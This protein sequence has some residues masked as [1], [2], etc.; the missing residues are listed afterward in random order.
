MSFLRDLSPSGWDSL[1]RKC[2]LCCYEKQLSPG[3]AVYDLSEPCP[4]LDR[5]SQLCTVY[6]NRYRKNPRCRPVNLFTAM[7]ASY[8]PLCCGYTAWAKKYHLR[9]VR[10]REIS[11]IHSIHPACK[12]DDE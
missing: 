5:E 2:G 3:T 10:S 1:C 11:Y 6:K 8:L 7:F 9:L 4:L 12:L